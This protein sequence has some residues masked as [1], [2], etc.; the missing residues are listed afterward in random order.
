[1]GVKMNAFLEKLPDLARSIGI[2]ESQPQ[3]GQNGDKPFIELHGHSGQI[4]EAAY[5]Q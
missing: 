1:M 4:T 3:G 2:H 5:Q